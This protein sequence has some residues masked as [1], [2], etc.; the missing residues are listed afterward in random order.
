VARRLAEA[1]GGS[2]SVGDRPGG[3]ARFVFEAR[4]EALPDESAIKKASLSGLK[5]AV[6]GAHPFTAA[7]AGAMARD[8]GASLVSEASADLVLVDDDGRALDTELAKRPA[9]PHAVI[10]LR[11]GRRDRIA[12][13]RAGAHSPGDRP[14]PCLR[15]YRG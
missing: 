13:Y 12:D 14:R 4:F 3:G 11:P 7:A 9:S 15:Q 2:L 8:A 5:L 1:M 10:L 6:T